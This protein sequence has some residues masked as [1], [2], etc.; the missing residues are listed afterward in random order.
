MSKSS[1]Y[2]IV[3][4]GVALVLVAANV[5]NFLR[6]KTC[7]DCF[8]PYGIPFTL[9]QEGG[10]GGGAGIVWVGLLADAA[11]VIVSSLIVGSAWRAFAKKSSD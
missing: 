6:P 5:H 10:E 4:F 9:Y 7:Y 1:R 8:F 3:F 2:A 11:I